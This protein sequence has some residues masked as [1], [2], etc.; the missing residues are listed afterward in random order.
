M[1][2]IMDV[3]TIIKR[4]MPISNNFKKRFLIIKLQPFNT[5]NILTKSYKQNLFQISNHNH[6]R[7]H[8]QSP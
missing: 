4:S 8:V 1:K 6:K 2:N 7:S 3:T 5:L